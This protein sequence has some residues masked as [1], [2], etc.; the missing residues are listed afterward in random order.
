MITMHP[1]LSI[2]ILTCITLFRH[3]LGDNCPCGWW[4]KNHESI[5]TH[6]VYEDFGDYP[7]D[8]D[9]MLGNPLAA[10]FNEEWM[11]Y[12]Y[13]LSADNPAIRFDT[14]YGWHNV[15][16]KDRHLLLRQRG[17]SKADQASFATVSIAGIQSRRVDMLHGTYRAVFKLEGS[18]GG[19]CAGFFWY[20]VS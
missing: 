19:S 11:I 8:V 6:Q 5:Y 3:T 4:L 20:H 14:K 18:H 1:I 9:S 16:I 10:R 7:I 17:F 13:W 2:C 12:D 15:E